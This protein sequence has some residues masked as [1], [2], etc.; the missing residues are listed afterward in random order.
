VTDFTLYAELSSSSNPKSHR[1]SKSYWEVCKQVQVYST[2]ALTE[3][4]STKISLQKLIKKLQTLLQKLAN[5][6]KINEFYRFL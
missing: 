4:F 5:L 1:Y 3:T 2:G 6:S